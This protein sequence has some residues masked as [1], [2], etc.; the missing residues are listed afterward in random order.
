MR[1]QSFRLAIPSWSIFSEVSNKHPQ[2]R[3]GQSWGSDDGGKSGDSI[4]VIP[5]RTREYS[6]LT[7]CIA[8]FLGDFTFVFIG[9][10][11]DCKRINTYGCDS[12]LSG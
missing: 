12:P 11:A 1:R 9:K 8:E 7:K 2:D 6:L 4:S 10:Y 5:G 3:Y